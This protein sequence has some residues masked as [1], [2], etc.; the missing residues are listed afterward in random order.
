MRND[1]A[2]GL[3]VAALLITASVFVLSEISRAGALQGSGGNIN[4]VDFLGLFYNYT[5]YWQ[6]YYS[7]ITTASSPVLNSSY[8]YSSGSTNYSFN[9]SGIGI[10]TIQKLELGASIREG[11]YLLITTSPVP[12]VLTNLTAG[13]VS[14]IDAITGQG[15]ESG[16]NTFTSK[17][18]YRIP[19]TGGTILT[20][21]PTLY[22]FVES[23]PQF[24]YFKEGLLQDEN[25]TVVFA[26]PISS[27]PVPG[28]DGSTYYFQFIL[29]NNESNPLTYYMFY[30]P[31]DLPPGGGPGGPGGGGGGGGGGG[32]GPS[33]ENYTN[34]QRWEIQ[35]EYLRA[36]FSTS[37]LFRTQDLVIYEVVIIPAKSIG[38]VSIKIEQLK[39]LST[40]NVTMP[41]GIIYAHANVWVFARELKN[42]ENL[43]NAIVKFKIENKWLADNS[44][45]DS[46]IR[47]LRWNENKWV[48]LETELK[49]RDG[50]YTYYEAKTDGFEHFAVSVDPVYKVVPIYPME[51]RPAGITETPRTA[52]IPVPKI[53]EMN[54]GRGRI[55]VLAFILIGILLYRL[56]FKKPK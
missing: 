13:N 46:K 15:D 39:G 18:S 11:D 27:S 3:L 45:Y 35:E 50:N 6:G 7:V 19:Y 49:S 53:E 34:I 56:V 32:A 30:L 12:P 2:T 29:P 44:L 16:T 55:A 54:S 4:Q 26:V 28:Y 36:N 1:T 48:Q 51:K 20:D 52:E 37:Y 24:N 8:N 25:G 14:S 23:K 47:L 5:R 22:T 10:N 21:V 38:L 9:Q 42:P 43:K 41:P 33:G 17:S 40:M 31:S